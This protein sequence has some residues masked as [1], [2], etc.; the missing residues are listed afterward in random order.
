MQIKTPALVQASSNS[1]SER[2]LIDF[3]ERALAAPGVAGTE[4]VMIAQ[5]ASSPVARALL[6]KADAIAAARVTARI[7]F[8]REDES[9]EDFLGAG[10]SSAP[11]F[12]REIRISR[13]PRLRDA[14]EQLVI[15]ETDVWHGDSMRRDLNRRDVLHQ[16]SSGCVVAAEIAKRGFGRMWD[17]AEATSPC[18]TDLGLPGDALLPI[19]SLL[20]HGAAS[21]THRATEA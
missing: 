14:H 13:N 2:R 19:E 9:L 21:R 4:L 20:S 11:A 18:R 5:S 8:S 17:R 3:I 15:G 6:A 16:F 7:V 1:D 10:R 12:D